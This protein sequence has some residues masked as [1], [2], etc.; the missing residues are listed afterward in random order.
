MK[1]SRR[2]GA[3]PEADGENLLGEKLADLDVRG[4]GAPVMVIEVDHEDAGGVRVDASEGVIPEEVAEEEA[5]VV[6]V[7][8]NP[9]PRGGLHSDVVR[10]AVRRGR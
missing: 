3:N 5:G 4:E 2:G 6:S 7:P 10:D 1:P 9:G 8:L